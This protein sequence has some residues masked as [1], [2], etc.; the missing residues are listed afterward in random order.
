MSSIN[1]KD[2]LAENDPDL[3]PESELNTFDAF[4]QSGFDNPVE[5]PLGLSVVSEVP[6]RKATRKCKPFQPLIMTLT[7]LLLWLTLPLC[8]QF[9]GW[10]ELG[11]AYTDNAFQLSGYDIR[12][13]ETGNPELK[14]AKASDDVILHAKLNAAYELQWHW[15]HFQP[16]LQINSAQ[17][18]LNP[19]KQKLDAT[20]GV[21]I[22][23]RLGEIG[24]YYGYYPNV[25]LRDYI[26]TGGTN[27][28]QA[29]AYAKNQYRADL[30]LKPLKKSTA[31]LE[32][33][34]EDFFYNEYFTEFD[35]KIETWKLGWQQSLPTFY[36]DASYAFR[37][38]ETD[39][40]KIVTASEDASYESNIYSVG[41]QMKKMPVDTKYPNLLWRPELKLGY[42][43]RYFQG[44]DNWHAGRTDII[45]NTDATLQFYFGSNWNINL[46]YSHIFRNVDA[47]DSSVQKYKDYSENQCGVSARYRF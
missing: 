47:I 25:Y 24:L 45:N 30:Q 16:S 44:S 4:I 22:S 40:D 34:R 46:D 1:T 5:L 39:A 29:F 32:F 6:K 35:G 10:V 26:D 31:T 9:S 36:L 8:A 21:I 12:R 38:Y 43:Q 20:A 28:L 13:F 3:K 7:M 17:N 2:I 37:V 19:D 41:I 33:K 42:E 15:W 18:V 11:S 27:Q 14:F 23:R